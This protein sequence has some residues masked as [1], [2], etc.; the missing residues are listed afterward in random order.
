MVKRSKPIAVSIAIA[1]RSRHYWQATGTRTRM[2]VSLLFGQC[3]HIQPANYS[4]IDCCSKYA[5][6]SV[7]RKRSRALRRIVEGRSAYAIMST[8]MAASLVVMLFRINFQHFVQ[9]S[10]D[11]PMRSITT[12]WVRIQA[13]NGDTARER[14]EKVL[15][16][17]DDWRAQ[18]AIGDVDIY[19]FIRQHGHDEICANMQSNDRDRFLCPPPPPYPLLLPG[20]LWKVKW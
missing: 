13:S 1:H 11:I 12:I 8:Q 6:M 7:A 2:C 19:E 9:C 16:F 10:G 18:T 15:S 17:S 5:Y 14:E 4:F 3:V 20:Q